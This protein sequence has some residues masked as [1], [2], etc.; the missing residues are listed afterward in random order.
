MVL[1]ATIAQTCANFPPALI[2]SVTWLVTVFAVA[3][4]WSSSSSSGVRRGP[5]ETSGFIPFVLKEDLGSKVLYSSS[6]EEEKASY[7]WMCQGHFEGQ[8]VNR[9][10][11]FDGED[12]TCWRTNEK[13][14]WTED[15]KK[16]ISLNCKAKSILCCTLSKKEFNRISACKST[17]EMW[18]KLRITYEGTDNVKETR[19]DILVTQ[20]HGICRKPVARSLWKPIGRLFWDGFVVLLHSDILLPDGSEEQEAC[21]PSPSSFSL[22]RRG[23]VDF[24]SLENM[25]LGLQ[26][27]FDT[28]GWFPFCYSHKRY[29]SAAV[30]EFYIN[31]R[32]IALGDLYTKARGRYKMLDGV[33]T[34]D[35]K[36]K[37]QAD[38][39]DE[40]DEDEANEDDADEDS[41]SEPMDAQGDEADAAA[42]EQAPDEPSLQDFITAQMVQMQLHMTTG[43]DHLNARLDNVDITLDAMVDTQV[44]LQIR[45]TRLSTELHGLC[46]ASPPLGNDDV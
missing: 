3:I 34:R 21:F 27:L 16:K 11:L 41:Q 7:G 10:P 43:F 17:M 20:W 8:S 2:S 35:L 23:Y 24:V 31:L 42:D 40:A 6:C 18:G 5:V 30:T 39:E 38:E 22:S 37:A 44:Q 36:G 12:Y 33:V 46:Q 14:K 19:I 45:L 28:Q 1:A 29:S 26:P 13:D 9:P 32:E 4:L 15:D 25:F